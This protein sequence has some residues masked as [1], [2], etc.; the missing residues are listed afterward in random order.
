MY[1]YSEE[2]S[3]WLRPYDIVHKYNKVSSTLPSLWGDEGVQA[4]DPGQQGALHDGWFLGAAASLAEHPAYIHR[5]FDE[6]EYTGS[7]AFELNLF[8]EGTLQKVIIDD[9]L[10]VFK[11][12]TMINARP[13]KNSGWWLPLLEKAY[14][15]ANVNYE[16]L[17]RGNGL[18]QLGA[19]RQLSAMPVQMIDIDDPHFLR[20]IRNVYMQGYALS[21]YVSREN[22]H[23]LKAGRSYN[24]ID[25]VE[26]EVP[27]VN[28]PK[29]IAVKLRDPWTG[30][31]RVSYSQ[32]LFHDFDIKPLDEHEK[33]F[34]MS[35]EAFESTFAFVNVAMLSDDWIVATQSFGKSTNDLYRMVIFNNQT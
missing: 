11:N 34:Y 13:S 24:I 5:I 31:G 8:L 25:L 26:Q 21:V 29:L 2:I 28:H 9:Q 6:Q 3:R 14:A 10:A 12:D 17:D 15:K 4:K 27:S 19:L 33:S 20:K 32:P 30:G 18:S 1:E 16:N 22:E 35:M 23:G 7:G